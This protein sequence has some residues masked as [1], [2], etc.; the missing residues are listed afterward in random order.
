MDVWYEHAKKVWFDDYL[1]LL[2]YAIQI[3]DVHWANEL[4]HT[5]KNAENSI[6]TL[7]NTLYERGLIQE[8][9]AINVELHAIF[10]MTRQQLEKRKDPYII[11]K[12]VSLKKRRSIL[13]QL[14]H[15]NYS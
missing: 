8:F 11:E 5:M 6:S 12:I 1:D 15:Q 9:D 4:L 2:S 13:I 10:L 3:N 14:L 7:S